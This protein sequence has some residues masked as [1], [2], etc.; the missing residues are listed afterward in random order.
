MS[1]PGVS[2][3]DSN[4]NAIT[5]TGGGLTVSGTVTA[6]VAVGTGVQAPQATTNV[7]VPANTANVTVRT[8]A[9]RLFS[10]TVTAVG[11]VTGMTFTDNGVVIAALTV[12]QVAAIG[13]VQINVPFTTNL[14]VVGGTTNASI[15]VA[16]GF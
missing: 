14:V 2:L 9:G 4:G 13:T 8:G 3:F 15:S 5:S 1:L 12:A 10:V 7:A 6:N 11:S 16:I